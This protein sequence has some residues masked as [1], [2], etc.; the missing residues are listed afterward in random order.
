M[1]ELHRAA[2]ESDLSR[3]HHLG[4]FDECFLDPARIEEGRRH[5][6]STIPQGYDEILARRLIPDLLQFGL[7]DHVDERDVFALFDIEIF[8]FATNRH[9]VA[10][11]AGKITQQLTDGAQTEVLFQRIGGL[12]ADHEVQAVIQCRHVTPPR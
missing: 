6:R 2:K 8:P 10:V 11:L 5:L 9:C 1:G 7:G 4:A 12:L 3:E